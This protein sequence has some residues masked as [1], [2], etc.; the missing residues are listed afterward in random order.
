MRA[1]GGD[2]SVFDDAEYVLLQYA[3]TVALPFG[4]ANSSA[5][6]PKNRH[7]PSS[8]SRTMTGETHC[9]RGDEAGRART[10]RDATVCDINGAFPS[11]TRR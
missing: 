3:R 7:D 5:G 11:G 2:F 4:A 10:P 8:S 9:K 6:R 1:I